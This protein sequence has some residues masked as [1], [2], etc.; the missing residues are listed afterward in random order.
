MLL[1]FA[2]AVIAALLLLLLPGI[3]WAWWRYPAPERSTRLAVGFAVGFAFQVHTC[4]LLAWGPGITQSTVLLATSFGITVAAVLVCCTR[5]RRPLPAGMSRRHSRQLV[6]LLGVVALPRLAPLILEQI[7]SGWDPSFHSLL[8]STTLASHRLPAWSPFE[9]IPSNYPYGSHVFIA[10]ISLVTGIAPD[11]VFAVLINGVL[12]TCTCLA[13]Y[14]LARR[15]LR[16]YA[17]ALSAVAAYGL[18]GNWGSIQYPLWGGLPNELGLFMLLVFLVVLFAPAYDRTRILVGG[19]ILGAI[20][21]SHH[22][23]MLTT[24]MLLSVYVTYLAVRWFRSPG[25][26]ALRRQLM[27]AFIRLS[28]MSV[29][30]VVTVS[31]YVIP[32]ALRAGSLGSTRVAQ[33]LDDLAGLPFEKNGLLLWVLTGIGGA[34]LIGAF[35]E[36]RWSHAKLRARFAAAGTAG[37]ARA[38][39]VCASATLL[40]AFVLCYYVYRFYSYNFTSAGQPF[41]LFTPTRFLTDL[42]YFLAFF[43]AIPLARL[44]HW[45]ISHL[46]RVNLSPATVRV[47]S[48]ASMRVAISIVV[49][50]TGITLLDVPAIQRNGHLRVGEADAFAWIR[51]HTPGNTLVVNLNPSAR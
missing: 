6:G 39:V 32:L 25:R 42:T 16:S 47:M 12:P 15:V 37:L 3:I 22:H 14:A 1:S 13:L 7:P 17:Y 44:W 9:Q 5:L 20:P 11:S 2:P 4:A 21:L 35:Q 18:L 41:T 27:H 49:I 29:L 40:V 36:N 33:F 43:A 8:A 45:S 38:F 31:Y 34:V 26:P 24:V 28:L 48:R 46:P 23:V 51:T 30:A 50:N 19:L 10:Q